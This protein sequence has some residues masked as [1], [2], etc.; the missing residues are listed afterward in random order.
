MNVIQENTVPGKIIYANPW[1]RL[2]A[3]LLDYALLFCILIAIQTMTWIFGQGFPFALFRDGIQIE[4]WILLSISL[5]A[6]LYFAFSEQSV[7][8]A[9]FGKRL[10]H[11]RVAHVTGSR[12]GFWR[13]L[14][15]TVVKLLPWELTHVALLIP[16]PM[17]WD[18]SP[19]LRVG[20][21]VIY[22]LIG[23]YFGVMFSNRRRQSVHDLLANTVVV[24]AVV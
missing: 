21:I 12:I 5:P 10:F 14:L 16:V 8:Q 7:H 23:I 13:A 24:K 9:T 3:Y 17:W 2:A 6:W 22:L 15:R 1:R 4:L 20:L 11:L 19:G 18:P